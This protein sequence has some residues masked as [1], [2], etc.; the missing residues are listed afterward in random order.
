MANRVRSVA[1]RYLHGP[2]DADAAAHHHA[3]HEHGRGLGIG[4]EQVVEAIFVEEEIARRLAR[5][6]GAPGDGDDVAAGAEAP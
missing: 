1:I 6:L 4:E 2:R 5:A 3:V